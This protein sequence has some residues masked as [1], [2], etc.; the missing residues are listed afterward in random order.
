M[1]TCA[2][3]SYTRATLGLLGSISRGM[4]ARSTLTHAMS[5]SAMQ[6]LPGQPRIN[7]NP[8]GQ[9]YSPAPFRMRLDALRGLK[10][11]SLV[12]VRTVRL[13][14]AT[15]G[16]ARNFPGD[17]AVVPLAGWAHYGMKG[18]SAPNSSW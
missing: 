17:G 2:P 9:N 1:P 15:P 5:L 18:Q 14:E 10:G 7:R 11:G 6:S 8:Y 12:L 13:I 4:C 16:S 3:A